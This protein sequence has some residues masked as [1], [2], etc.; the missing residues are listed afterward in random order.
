MW[1]LGQL[2]TPH[3]QSGRRETDEFWG[4]AHFLLLIQSRHGDAHIWGGGGVFP[5]QLTHSRNALED[6]TRDLFP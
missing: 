4:E 5:S 2:V 6:M 1:A 3:P